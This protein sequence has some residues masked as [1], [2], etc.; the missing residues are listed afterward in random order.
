MYLHQH[1]K[2]ETMNYL[3]SIK[4][5]HT[6]TNRHQQN[7]RDCMDAI[8]NH[9]DE[10]LEKEEELRYNINEDLRFTREVLSE[11]VV[12][13][14]RLKVKIK[15]LEMTESKL[16]T[17]LDIAWYAINEAGYTGFSSNLNKFMEG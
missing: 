3:Q 1:T 2:G 16:T 14:E 12:E 15:E 7:L 11:I 6:K 10:E 4:N 17:Y 5:L 8:A 9:A 13:N